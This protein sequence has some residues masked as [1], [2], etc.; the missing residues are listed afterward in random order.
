MNY[1]LKNQDLIDFYT[2]KQFQSKFMIEQ[3]MR[4]IENLL[5]QLNKVKNNKSAET[6]YHL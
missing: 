5:N 3:E 4:E 1:K 6:Q 2:L